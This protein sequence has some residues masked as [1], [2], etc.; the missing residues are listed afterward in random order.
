MPMDLSRY[1]PDWHD[2]SLKIRE[3][4]SWRCQNCNI[5]CRRSNESLEKFI[6]REFKGRSRHR[7][8]ARDHPKRYCLTVAHLDQNS[9]DRDTQN[10][11]A[12]CCPCHLNYDRPWIT[13]NAYAKRE[14]N[15]QLPLP[16]KL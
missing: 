10:L 4:A 5:P 11:K 12:L 16:L 9:G 8:A 1:P 2:L 14:F 6:Q 15:G 3:T 7:Q 13:H